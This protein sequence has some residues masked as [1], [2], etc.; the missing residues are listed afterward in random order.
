[1]WMLPIFESGQRFTIDEE[2]A[3]VGIK[4]GQRKVD[5]GLD[6]KG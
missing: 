2:A 1:M 6:R 3:A 4:L 5:E